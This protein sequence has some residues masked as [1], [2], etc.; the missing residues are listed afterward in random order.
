MAAGCLCGLPM[1]MADALRNARG[2]MAITSKRSLLQPRI[3]P[4]HGPYGPPAPSSALSASLNIKL[5]SRD[6]PAHFSPTRL[7]FMS[8]G[9]EADRRGL[10]AA[11]PG[12]GVR[13]AVPPSVTCSKTLMVYRV[14]IR[15]SRNLLQLPSFIVESPPDQFRS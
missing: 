9:Q 13:I 3:R 14:K 11:A 15:V 8:A 1:Q 4:G 6:A 12:D 7:S 5:G 10:Q 2:D